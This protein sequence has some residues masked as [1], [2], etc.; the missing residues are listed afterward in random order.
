MCTNQ[1]VI[2]FYLP[3]YFQ[4]SFRIYFWK[5]FAIS[6]HYVCDVAQNFIASLE[7]FT[8]VK[9]KIVVFWN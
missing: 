3:C 1:L 7:V 8:T 5:S 2:I 4:T 6:F 9:S